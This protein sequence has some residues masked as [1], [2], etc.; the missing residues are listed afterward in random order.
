ME[1]A[2]G[3]DELRPNLLEEVCQIGLS[4]VKDKG[5]TVK[6]GVT[7]PVKLLPCFAGDAAGSLASKTAFQI[8]LRVFQEFQIEIFTG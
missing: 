5:I 7:D 4:Y 6:K 3:L 2:Q 1:A 8:R